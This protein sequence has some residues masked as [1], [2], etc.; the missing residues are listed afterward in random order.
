M[1]KSQNVI[2][3]RKTPLYALL[4][5]DN[6]RFYTLIHIIEFISFSS[7]NREFSK[8]T[9]LKQGRLRHMVVGDASPTTK[10]EVGSRMR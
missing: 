7:F 10:Q 8:M 1:R 9:M 3:V 2:T 5:S 6:E 4:I